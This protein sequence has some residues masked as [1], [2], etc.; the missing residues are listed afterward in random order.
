MAVSLRFKYTFKL[1]VCSKMRKEE[2][3]YIKIIGIH[4]YVLGTYSCT[5]IQKKK[6]INFLKILILKRDVWVHVLK[7]KI[8]VHM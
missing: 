4:V 2:K 7:Y 1:K 8:L 3:K 5:H 6:K